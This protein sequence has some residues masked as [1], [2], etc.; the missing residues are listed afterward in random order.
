M[1][2]AQILGGDRMK[3]MQIVLISCK[4]FLLVH[5]ETLAGYETGFGQSRSKT[6]ANLHLFAFLLV[7]GDRDSNESE[8]E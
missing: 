7:K 1:I 8:T 6:F 5:I 3:P 4:I 2:F